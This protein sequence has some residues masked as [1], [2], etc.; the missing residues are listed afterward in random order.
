MKS[1]IPTPAALLFFTVMSFLAV[2][3]SFAAPTTDPD[4]DPTQEAAAGDSWVIDSGE[5]WNEN[6]ATKQGLEINKGKAT[7]TE[8]QATFTSVLKRYD[9]KRSAK[10]IRFEQSPEWL[11]WSPAGNIGPVNL[12][13]AP[14]FLS[15][16]PNNY[17]MFG[18]YGSKKSK[19]G[20]KNKGAKSKSGNENF[21]PQ[22]AT[23]EGFEVPLKTTPFAHQFDA[24]GALKPKQGGYHAWQSK[25]M[26]NW[27]HHGSITNA[28]GKWM[29]TAEHADGKAYFYYDF[30]NDQDPHVYVDSDLFDG[31]PGENMGM[32]YKDPSDGSDCAIIRD[33]DGKFHLILE[34]WSPIN[35]RKHAWDSPLAAHAVSPDGLKDFKALAPPVDERTTPTG[36]TKTYKHP[37][38]VKE[39]PER[40]KTNV[41]EYEV[42]KPEQNAY[43]D[44]AAISIGGR[45]Y[46]F[47]DFDPAEKKKMSVGWFTSSSIDEQFEW[48]GEI[49]E[50]HPDPDV[51][52][53]EG[54]FYLATQQKEDFIS[55]GPW[56]ED[57]EVRVGVDTDNDQTIDQWTEWTKVKE[58]YDYIEGFSKQVAK[59]PAQVD[60]SSLPEGFGFQ[61]EV[62]LNDTTENRSKPI[63]ETVELMFGG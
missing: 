59:T 16:G 32:A 42:H 34:D 58:T 28:E 63:L 3:F 18:R 47:C 55:P 40:F 14:V 44:W 30:P 7:P 43:G 8:T 39:N 9:V 21:T 10:S 33:L 15:L 13:D 24:P 5:S 19:R 12:G 46:M 57:V 4:N 1:T 56:V 50:G 51:M 23:L 27:V 25:D 60:L 2:S 35:A 62:K 48:C 53:A 29:T 26:V 52:F 49:G 22:D 20:K 45:Y 54:K 41:A 36:E 6:I 31:M 11:N 38:W 37:H 61:F 17:W